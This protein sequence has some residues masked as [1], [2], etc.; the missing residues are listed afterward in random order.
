MRAFQH[1]EAL[2]CPLPLAN[3]DTDQLI[4]ARFMRRTRQEGYGDQLL[5]DL[6]FLADG[7]PNW[8]FPLND[9]RWKG[10]RILVA[11]RNF[12]SG[13]SREA[14]VYALADFGVEVVIAPS[15]GDIFAQNAVNN[16]LLPARTSET[17][18]ERLIDWLHTKGTTISID[19]VAKRI[20][21]GHI[22]IDF[23]I[24]PVWR[25]KLLN[26]WDDLDLTLSRREE[27]AAF[28]ARDT[29]QRPW[30]KP[31]S[32]RPSSLEPP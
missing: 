11:R 19:L 12:G 26:G 2:A 31:V 20:L 9:P 14:A 30:V 13:S 23:D 21:A 5:H 6:R 32:L 16:G 7:T 15:F 27:I 25:T 22:A 3:I 24:D 1:I 17:D 10:A 28:M 8:D 18:T 4:P 29:L